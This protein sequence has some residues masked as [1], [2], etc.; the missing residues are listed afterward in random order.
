LAVLMVTVF[1]LAPVLLAS[2]LVTPAVY[3]ALGFVNLFVL[4]LVSYPGYFKTLAALSPVSLGL[5]GLNVLFPS[6][7]TD[8][9]TRGLSLFLRSFSLVS[10]SVGFI[11]AVNPYELV[12]AM[13]IRLRLSPRAGF[14]FFAGWNAVPLLKR[15]LAIIRKARE[16]RYG[17]LKQPPPR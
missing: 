5:L 12:R 7:G 11:H 4:G 10:L 16:I 14:A 6:E 15:D 9:W 1:L 2:D 13:M 17:A 3:M 8:G